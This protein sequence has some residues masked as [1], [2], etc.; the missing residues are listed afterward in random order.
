MQIEF[1]TTEQV[2]TMLHCEIST[3]AG[4]ACRGELPAT[5]IGKGYIF[6]ADDVVAF[7]RAKIVADTAERR[8]KRDPAQIMAIAM[9]KA[10]QGSGR[11]RTKLPVLPEL[12]QAA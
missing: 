5:S 1:M 12:R 9:S 8:L 11:R 10:S 2:A 7:V 3:V 6:V 4:L